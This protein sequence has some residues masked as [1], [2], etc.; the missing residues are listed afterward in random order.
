MAEPFFLRNQNRFEVLVERSYNADAD[1]S[2]WK[3]LQV[4][5]KAAHGW[6]VRAASLDELTVGV[7]VPVRICIFASMEDGRLDFLDEPRLRSQ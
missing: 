3:L 6:K 4:R 1:C 2:T 5:V 7:D